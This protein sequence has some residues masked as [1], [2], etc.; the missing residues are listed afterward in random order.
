MVLRVVCSLAVE[1]VVGGAA[2]APSRRAALRI[3][4]TRTWRFLTSPLELFDLLSV[5]PFYLERTLGDGGGGA[6]SLSALRLLRLTRVTR[7]FKL[8]KQAE[9]TPTSHV[10]ERNMERNG[11]HRSSSIT[12]VF[13]APPRYL[14][15]LRSAPRTPLLRAGVPH[16]HQRDRALDA[17]NAR[18]RDLLR[19]RD[20]GYV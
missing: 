2:A 8:G 9:V 6:S 10:T 13:S 18:A 7:V 11:M 5:L 20:G 19:A 14:C 3:G 1:G 12:P 15:V 16:V 17:R 4:A